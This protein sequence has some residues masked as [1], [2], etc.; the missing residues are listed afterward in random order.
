MKTCCQYSPIAPACLVF[1]I[2]NVQFSTALAQGSLTPPGAPAPTMKTLEQIEPRT[3]IS[4]LPFNITNSGSYYVTTNLT[5]LYGQDGI[6]V[7]ADDVSIDLGGFTLTGISSG[8]AVH[9]DGVIRNGLRV[10]HGNLR[11]WSSGVNAAIAQ[12]SA[13]ADLTVAVSSNG[14]YLGNYSTVRQCRVQNQNGNLGIATGDHSV[15]AE[16]VA[17]GD[18]GSGIGIAGGSDS[19]IENCSATGNGIGISAGSGSIIRS[20][21]AQNNGSGIS[22]GNEC[23]V[24]DSN[25]SG[26]TATGISV[27]YHSQVSGCTADSNS[28][29]GIG[30]VNGVQI[31]KCLANNNGN[32][33]AG[34]GIDIADDGAIRGCVAQG[35]QNDGI[36]V[37]GNCVVAEN[38]AGGNG[39]GT[40][41]SAGI[42][43]TGGG[44][45]IDS[46]QTRDN[47]GRG[48]WAASISTDNII[49][50]NS[51]GNNAG[52]NYV[53]PAGTI[54]GPTNVISGTI[55]DNNPWR[56]F[57][58]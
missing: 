32:G 34:I 44:N 45:R 58:F 7:G 52:G 21:T 26:N 54:A 13:C 9:A 19:V 25:A 56:N 17:A 24:R 47:L 3:P 15:V 42:R 18:P 39:L 29:S 49:I 30:G 41:A 31:V 38:H 50:R 20:C 22:T 16:C 2:L 28:G 55:T 11:G 57:S 14:I 23:A 46:N 48:I 40:T 5:G 33:T 53:F 35:N 10:W 27:S 37:G 1:F 43:S 8:S 12:R 4:S 36:R 51:S 6:V